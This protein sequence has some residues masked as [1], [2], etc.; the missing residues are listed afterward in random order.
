VTRARARALDHE[1][2][3]EYE[4]LAKRK[5][6][7]SA[8]ASGAN[9]TKHQSP[10]DVEL[11]ERL[12]K[13]MATNDLSAV[14]LRDGDRRV[15]LKRGALTAESGSSGVAH[16]VPAMYAP[17][18]AHATAPSS[19]A[20]TTPTAAPPGAGESD[21]DLLAIKSPMVGTFYSS[22]SPEA[23]AFVSVGSQVDEETD[24][25]IIE[26]MKVFNNIKAECRGTIAK[27]L[28]GNGET[29]EFGQ[30]LFLVK[31]S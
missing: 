21:K 4:H 9:S 20:S 28:V 8:R 2:R 29:V 12:V 1:H 16:H 11:L 7:N 3:E 10:M 23:P 19:G 15:V 14:D 17:S 13:L 30:V 31:P 24:V 22:P 6:N 18:H 27:T 25:C 5:S 26:A